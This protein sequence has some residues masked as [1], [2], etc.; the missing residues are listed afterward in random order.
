[1][2]F[3]FSPLLRITFYSIS[4]RID[5]AVVASIR[6]FGIRRSELLSRST[7]LELNR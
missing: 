7:K 6:E 3:E 4:P 5:D 1:M 2:K